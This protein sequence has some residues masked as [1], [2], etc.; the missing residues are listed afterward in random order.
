MILDWI[1]I[2]VTPGGRQRNDE[3]SPHA[4]LPTSPCQIPPGQEPMV[5]IQ[6]CCHNEGIV[7]EDTINAACQVDWPRD[8]N[9]EKDL[10]V[11]DCIE[12][13]VGVCVSL[14]PPFRFPSIPFSYALLLPRKRIFDLER[15]NVLDRFFLRIDR[16]LS[17]LRWF[18]LIANWRNATL[19][20]NLNPNP[21]CYGCQ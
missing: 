21:K 11:D 16:R 5:T 6:V 8:Q 14:F 19:V 4:V 3:W 2:T 18:I 1:H 20:S 15:T 13:H 7:I 17:G 10:I 9:V 12:S